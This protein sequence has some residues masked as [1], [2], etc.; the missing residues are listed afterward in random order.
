MSAATTMLDRN[1]TVKTRSSKI[2][3]S[4]A[5]SPPKTASSAATTAIGRY[6]CSH[7]GTVGSSTSPTMTPTSRPIAAI[8]GRPPGGAWRGAAGGRPPGGGGGGPAEGAAPGAP[9]SDADGDGDGVADAA[10]LAWT[11]RVEKP[12]A[13]G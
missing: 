3:S 7:T 5:R 6:G 13:P 9:G 8:T 10:L 11:N 1:D 2:Q 4:T 12:P